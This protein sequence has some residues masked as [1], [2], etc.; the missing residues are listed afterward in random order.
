M[1]RPIPHA[2]AVPDGLHRCAGRSEAGIHDVDE[3]GI[4]TLKTKE[5]VICSGG[6]GL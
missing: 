1:A 6:L 3:T 5:H 2:E 4:S